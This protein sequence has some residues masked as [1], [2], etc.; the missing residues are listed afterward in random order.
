MNDQGHKEPFKLGVLMLDTHFI[1]I[2]GDIGYPHTFPFPVVYRTVK[3]ADVRRVIARGDTSLIS[4]FIEAGWHLVEQ[5]ATLIT[6][7]CGFLASFQKEI[8]EALE[9]PFVSS[10]LLQL[11]L[12]YHVMGQRG[13]IGI[14]TASKVHLSKAHFEGVG[15]A[16]IPVTIAGMDNAT[17]FNQAIMG[18]TVPLN[19]QT[20][21]G[22]VT[23]V[24]KKLLKNSPDSPALILECTNLSPY[25]L[26]IQEQVKRPIFD[27]VT[28][29][30]SF[31]EVMKN[32]SPR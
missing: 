12:L 25:R 3:G 26:K 30:L 19:S 15:A 17:H 7:S 20:L 5:G 8:A 28:L 31:Y 21:E 11:P 22:E 29:L 24:A 16:D 14:L 6:T 9:V 27:L 13:P 1:R 10:S 18:E 23:K 4:R 2:L 32:S